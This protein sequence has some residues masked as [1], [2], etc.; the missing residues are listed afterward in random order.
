MLAYNKQFVI[1]YAGYEHKSTENWNYLRKCSAC[2]QYKISIK[3]V[4]RVIGYLGS[5]SGQ[6]LGYKKIKIEFMSYSGLKQSGI[7][8]QHEGSYYQGS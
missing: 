8:L 5:K 1:Q 2:L 4:K 6:I 3:S 7:Y